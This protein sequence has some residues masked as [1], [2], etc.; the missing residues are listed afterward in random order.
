MASL[1][2]QLIS[3]KKELETLKSRY[4]A[5]KTKAAVDAARVEQAKAAAKEQVG[6]DDVNELRAIASKIATENEQEVQK[7]L[8]TIASIKSVIEE[9]EKETNNLA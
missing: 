6:T 1:E 4:D 9:L 3:G 7:F 8:Q 5:L 2:E